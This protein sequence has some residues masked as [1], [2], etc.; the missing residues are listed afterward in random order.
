MNDMVSASNKKTEALVSAN[1]SHDFRSLWNYFFDFGSGDV[2]SFEPKVDI[3]ENKT[4]VM[5]IAEV[6]GIKEED[7]DLKISE[8]GYLTISGEKQNVTEESAKHNYFKEISYGMFK[9]TIPLPLDLDY[10]MAEAEYENG[11]LSLNIP[12]LQH[13]KAKFKKI[14]V[15]K[16]N[17]EQSEKK[18][19]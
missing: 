9:R 14:N 7:I 12:K 6:P 13:Q 8:D 16:K 15:K 3:T 1:H 2:G 19:N 5:V 10:N 11:V 18:D 4:S 17:K